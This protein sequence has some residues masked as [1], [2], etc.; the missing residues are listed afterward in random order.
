M[1]LQRV[2]HDLATDWH[3]LKGQQGHQ[4]WKTNLERGR[5]K[6]FLF[7]PHPQTSGHWVLVCW[8]VYYKKPVCLQVIPGTPSQLDSSRALLIYLC[9]SLGGL[10]AATLIY[11]REV[12]FFSFGA[13]S[14]GL[15]CALALHGQVWVPWLPGE[16]SGERA[17]CSAQTLP[18]SGQ[19]NWPCSPDHPSPHHQTLGTWSPSKGVCRE[20]TNTF[21]NTKPVF[22]ELR[23]HLCR[24]F[25]CDLV[26]LTSR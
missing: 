12:S 26:L 21:P 4:N 23:S 13:K 15:L 9:R 1:G 5:R 16:F 7:H 17:V 20:E 24:W 25:P 11:T 3:I 18:S 2:G 10:R 6:E 14:C 19:G 22:P 8:P